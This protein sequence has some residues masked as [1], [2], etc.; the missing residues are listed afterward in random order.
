MKVKSAKIQKK[1]NKKWIVIVLFSFTFLFIFHLMR[2]QAKNKMDFRKVSIYSWNIEDVNDAM[3]IEICDELNINTFYQAISADNLN[4]DEWKKLL[5]ELTEKG[6]DCYL[7]Q[8]NPKQA[9]E[10]GAES[11]KEVVNKVKKFNDENEYKIKG[12]VWDVEF[13]LDKTQYQ[14]ESKKNCFER[15][16]KNMLEIYDY[17]KQREIETVQVIPYWLDTEIGEEALERL[18]KN[19]CDSIEVMNYYKQRAKEHIR[20]EIDY[21]KK[22]DKEIVTIAELQEA[23]GVSVIDKISFYQDGLESCQKEIKEILDTYDYEKLGYAYH[24]YKYLKILYEN[25]K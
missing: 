5:K 14:E 15:Y 10:E 13:Y 23:D 12:I 11:M 1:K 6:I 21:A 9:Y 16:Y 8:G 19:T 17:A 22:Y 24:Y 2:L 25:Q 4:T 3:L 20:N 18:I 7:L